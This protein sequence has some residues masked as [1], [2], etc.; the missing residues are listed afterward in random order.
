M[1]IFI[2]LVMLAS[3]NAYSKENACPKNSAVFTATKLGTTKVAGASFLQI[4]RGTA[5]LE[6]GVVCFQY[7][8]ILTTIASLKVSTELARELNCRLKSIEALELH[9]AFLTKRVNDILGKDLLKQCELGGEIT[10]EAL[11][12]RE[13]FELSAG[14]ALAGQLI[15][16]LTL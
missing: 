10:L 11:S 5:R 3:L 9:T 16:F 6:K 14:F 1:K 15:N 2:V 8:Q 4:S 7:A 13:I 12:N